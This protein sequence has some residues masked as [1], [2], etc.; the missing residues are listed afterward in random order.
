MNM[1]NKFIFIIIFLLQVC[2]VP[3]AFADDKKDEIEEELP[4]IDP[5]AGSTGSDSLNSNT[6]GSSGLS[7]SIM[8]NMKLVGTIGGEN[9]KIAVL[10]MPDGRMLTFEENSY[11]TNDMFLMD[12]LTDLIIIK[13]GN[14]DEEYEVYM[15]STIKP[16]EGN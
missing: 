3:L 15:N 12:V 13:V 11:I 9:K 4:A 2:L 1:G 7:S 5:F 16:R 10:S 8:N 14:K 6:D